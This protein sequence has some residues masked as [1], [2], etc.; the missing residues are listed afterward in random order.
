MRLKL[1]VKPSL[2]KATLRV[3]VQVYLVTFIF[4]FVS[5][6][7][8]NIRIF[9]INSFLIMMGVV[10]ALLEIGWF[11]FKN[12]M[13]A[14]F[15]AC[16]ASLVFAVLEAVKY[17]MTFEGLLPND[18]IVIFDPRNWHTDYFPWSVLVAAVLFIVCNALLLGYLSVKLAMSAMKKEW[19]PLGRL[20]SALILSAGIVNVCVHLHSYSLLASRDQGSIPYFFYSFFEKQEKP[21]FDNDPA[22]F[23][24]SFNTRS[25]ITPVPSAIKPDIMV[26]LHESTLNPNMLCAYR[27][28]PKLSLFKPNATTQELGWGRVHTFGGGTWLTEFAFL[29]G[30]NSYDFGANR[31]SVFYTVTPHLQDSF[32]KNL[33]KAGYTTIAIVPQERKD[34]YNSRSAYKDFGFDQVLTVSEIHPLH[35]TTG[36]IPDDEVR[37]AM[38]QVWQRYKNRPVFV[39]ALSLAEHAPYHGDFP[40]EKWKGVLDD[41]R[42]TLDAS[43]QAKYQDYWS[44]LLPLSVSMEKLE[45]EVLGQKEKRIILAS[46]GDHHPYLRQDEAKQEKVFCSTSELANPKFLTYYKI[47]DNFSTIVKDQTLFWKPQAEDLTFLGSNLLVRTGLPLSP[48]FAANEHLRKMCKGEMNE[49]S[50]TALLKSFKSYIYNRLDTYR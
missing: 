9:E 10:F 44:R 11:L 28:F 40:K 29:S 21:L 49:C 24:A 48:L 16:G 35:F 41:S 2:M 4:L 13:Y 17:G 6:S 26:W 43:L 19:S 1:V 15:L 20:I 33:K 42:L 36:F 25:V 5:A 12:L 18:F 22:L 23:E 39:Y 32:V 14:C 31:Q 27:T 38:V 3:Y 37:E 47:Q 7:P 34:F 50:N 8:Y 30:L 45:K 46:F